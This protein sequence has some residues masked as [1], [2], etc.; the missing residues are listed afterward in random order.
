MQINAQNKSQKNANANT[1]DFILV[2]VTSVQSPSN[3]LEIFLI[4]I[5]KHPKI[6][7]STPLD[8]NLSSNLYISSL[9]QEDTYLIGYNIS[10]KP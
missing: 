6:N 1:R 7:F 10:Y 2:P 3:S 4:L 5:L 9:H 8:K